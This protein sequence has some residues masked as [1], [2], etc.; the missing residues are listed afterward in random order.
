MDNADARQFL[1]NH[2]ALRVLEQTLCSAAAPRER[3]VGDVHGRNSPG[4][5]WCAM[6]QA[7]GV[8]E[9]PRE[10]HLRQLPVGPCWGHPVRKAQ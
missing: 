4:R 10:A 1:A 2:C 3:A 7:V 8:V 5:W 6:K 9:L